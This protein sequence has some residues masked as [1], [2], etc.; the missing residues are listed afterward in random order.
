MTTLSAGVDVADVFAAAD[1]LGK[2]S[3]DDLGK[4]SMQVVNE[5][6]QRARDSTIASIVAGVNLTEEYVREKYTFTEAKNPIAPVATV[7]ASGDANDLTLLSRYG[8]TQLTE[9]VNWTNEVL[10]KMGR[11]LVPQSVPGGRFRYTLRTGDKGR[12]IALGQKS[13][14]IAVD[15]RRGSPGV[16][17][18]HAFTRALKNGNGIGVFTRGSDGKTLKHRYGPSVYQLFRHTADKM[19]DDFESDLQLT[20]LVNLDDELEKITK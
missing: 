10:L 17:L 13:A 2:L 8:P 12:G 5:V 11:K 1:A 16:T 15:I 18:D 19:Q 20:L 4:M 6:A 9:N 3:A 14:G 7:T